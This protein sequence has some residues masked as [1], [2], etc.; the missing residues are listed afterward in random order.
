RDGDPGTGIDVAGPHNSFV[1]FL[2]RLGIPAFLALAF[3]VFIAARNAWRG[4]RDEST[5]VTDRVTVT[6][7]LAMLFAG[8]AAS[9]FNE[10]LTGPFLGL[11]F[12]VPLGMLLLWPAAGRGDLPR[13]EL[14]DPAG[15]SA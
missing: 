5:S 4:V 8:I 10:G 2:Y 6:T 12:W 14:R 13:D 15:R 11:F 3:I 1:N 7:L 9:G